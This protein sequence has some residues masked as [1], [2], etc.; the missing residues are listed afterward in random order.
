MEINVS[1]QL[2]ANIGNVREYNILDFIDI[3]EIGV[4]TRIEGTVK[5][6]R[7]NRGILVQGTLQATVPIECS[8]C[9][10]GFDYTIQVNIEEEYFPVIDV[11]S[12]IPLEVPDD[13][14]SFTI[15]EHH[16]LDLRE[17]IRQNALLAIPM[18]P[19]CSEDCAGL[20]YKCGIDINQGQ[21][22]CEKKNV[23]PRWSKLVD[24][25][26]AGKYTNKHKKDT[27]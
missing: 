14:N 24:F 17:A 10:K 25:A 21:C 9:L 18:K 19:L 27:E 26:S 6:T 13:P 5:L 15:D 11:N 4:S 23:D 1:Q 12:G 22:E 8:R 7:T 20:C 2:K 3:L 16:I